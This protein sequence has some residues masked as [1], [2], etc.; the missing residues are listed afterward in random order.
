MFFKY[1]F[2]LR[3]LSPVMDL[4]ESLTADHSTEKPVLNLNSV[5]NRTGLLAK[6]IGLLYSK[7]RHSLRTLYSTFFAV[8]T[9]VDQTAY[10]KL[11]KQ[12]RDD[13]FRYFSIS[14]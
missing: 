6:A 10:N 8:G 11:K 9:Y 14:R 4:R 3:V 13:Y 1:F 7:Y 2:S 5:L 12:E